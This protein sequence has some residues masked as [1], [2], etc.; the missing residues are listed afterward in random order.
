MELPVGTGL[1]RPAQARAPTTTRVSDPRSPPTG[2]TEEVRHPWSSLLC[3][4]RLNYG[5]LTSATKRAR[6]DSVLAMVW[7]LLSIAGVLAFAIF[8]SLAYRRQWQWTGLPVVRLETKATQVV[9]A[10]TLWD[11]LQ[12]LVVPAALATLAFVL[13]GAQA[14]HERSRAVDAAQETSL[15]TYLEQMSKLLLD[16]KIVSPSSQEEARR[17]SMEKRD[18]RVV[19]RS[20]TLA[21]LRRLDG[22]RRA[23][24]VKFLDDGGLLEDPAC[25]GGE[26]SIAV[27]DLDDADLRH[28]ELRGAELSGDDFARTDLRDADLRDAGL[29]EGCF[30]YT[31]LRKAHLERADLTGTVLACA[32]LRGAHLEGAA[33]RKEDLAGAVML[34]AHL[35]AGGGRVVAGA[36]TSRKP[37]RRPPHK[38]V[39]GWYVDAG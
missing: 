33:F 14:R 13:S 2:E 3:C 15:R 16:R 24:T 9:P 21:I 30:A 36:Q 8:V 19:A 35:D 6:D 20:A 7:L 39:A 4:A 25:T 23:L 18:G 12:L 32:D 27:V 38:S 1:A 22:D 17:L 29:R 11:W 34:G 31:D 26:R 28:A 5:R 37:C 10:K